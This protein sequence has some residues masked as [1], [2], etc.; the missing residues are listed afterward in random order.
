MVIE[1]SGFDGFNR[2]ADNNKNA[3]LTELRRL[4]PE[5][6]RVLEVGS[7][8]GQHVVHFAEALPG[9]VWQPTDRGDYFDMLKSNLAKVS[10]PNV[11]KPIYLEASD[12]PASFSDTGGFNAGY[13]A[14]VLHIMAE[15]FM[16]S[17]FTGV[18]N[19]LREGGL[20]VIY[21]PFKYGGDFTTP[22]NAQFD[23]WLKSR[24]PLSG[25]RDIEV[26]EQVAES[27]SLG[28]IED[29]AMPANNQLLVFRKT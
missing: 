2:A 15:S 8:S 29:K 13:L 7:G 3:I 26:V 5:T 4:L 17:L 18:S 19:S 10:L 21:G 16:A 23:E 27:V 22:S 25:V 1:V 12:F 20:C 14:N 11:L 6:G 24:D 28:L 9:I